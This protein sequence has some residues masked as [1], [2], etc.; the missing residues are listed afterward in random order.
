MY[1][2]YNLYVKTQ[3][4]ECPEQRWDTPYNGLLNLKYLFEDFVGTKSLLK[5]QVPPNSI[6]DTVMDSFITLKLG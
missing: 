4:A 3:Q 1:E 2:I 5:Y 6:M